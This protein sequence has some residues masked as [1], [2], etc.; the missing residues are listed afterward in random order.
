MKQLEEKP[1]LLP[2]LALVSILLPFILSNF[3][4]MSFAPGSREV[5]VEQQ[6]ERIVGVDGG[7]AFYVDKNL[8]FTEQPETL[9]VGNRHLAYPGKV[10]RVNGEIKEFVLYVHPYDL[11]VSSAPLGEKKEIDLLALF[12]QA[13]ISF[14]L[15][16][17][18][19]EVYQDGNQDILTI[20]YKDHDFL[21]LNLETLT[22]TKEEPKQPLRHFQANFEQKVRGLAISSPSFEFYDAGV[23]LLIGKRKRT[24][25]IL[26][27]N[28]YLVDKDMTEEDF[29][30]LLKSWL[31]QGE[32]IVIVE[33]GT[34]K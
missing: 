4:Y 26:S 10:K 15:L 17:L 1:Y 20:R 29:Y 32:K 18:T 28:L 3:L 9:A 25:E 12:K 27:H 21:Y 11:Q 34:R 5:E 8:F 16:L 7:K 31:P 13:R 33:R 14:D 19:Q 22:L 23:P 6:L 30:A 24:E 2:I